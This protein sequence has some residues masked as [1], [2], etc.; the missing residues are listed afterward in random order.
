MAKNDTR[1]FL[2]CSSAA[3]TFPSF[4]CQQQA[5]VSRRAA[6]RRLKC[7]AKFIGIVTFYLTKLTDL[8]K[9]KRRK[10]KE[11]HGQ[12]KKMAV[13]GL[14]LGVSLRWVLCWLGV[15]QAC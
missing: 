13:K 9:I 2:L 8:R 11:K 15:L 10:N 3:V 14:I 7:C 6:R 1:S 12:R 4:L 5:T